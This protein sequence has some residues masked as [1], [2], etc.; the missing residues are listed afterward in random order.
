MAKDNI[1]Q[2]LVLGMPSLVEFQTIEE[3]V[4]LCKGLGLSFVELNMNLPIFTVAKI[5]LIKYKKL[6]SDNDIFFTFHINERIDIADFDEYIREAGIRTIEE[7]IEIAKELG[8]P[9]LNMHMNEGV[10]FSLPN[11]KVYLYERYREDYL[12]NVRAFG[13]RIAKVIGDSGIILCLENTGINNYEYI[14]MALEELLKHD[15]IK[16]TWDIGHDYSSDWND[17]DFLTRNKG[18]IMHFHIHDAIGKA[19]HLE[20]YSGEMEF[21]DK[22][23]LA[24]ENAGLCVI[25]VKT[26]ESLTKSINNLI[27]KNI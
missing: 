24:K 6:I 8:T 25:E 16:L 11:E 22:F 21:K 26:K 1:D 5:D 20:L 19:N 2:K 27:E 15:C 17:K 13:K 4:L 10:H 18:K 14:T 9:V 3:N 23:E 12:D 7:T